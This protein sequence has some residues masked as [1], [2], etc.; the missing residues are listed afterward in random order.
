VTLGTFKFGCSAGF[1][2]SGTGAC[3]MISAPFCKILSNSTVAPATLNFRTRSANETNCLRN[4]NAS[5]SAMKNVILPPSVKSVIILADGD[6]PGDEAAR[7]SA[8]RWLREGRMVKI[9][10]APSGKDFNNVLQE[11]S[12]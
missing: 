2:N 1:G 12:Q 3:L 11:V 10:R 4:A 9:A 7:I 6:T 8:R 5:T